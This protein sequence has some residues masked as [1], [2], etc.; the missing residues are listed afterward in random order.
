[1]LNVTRKLYSEII[2]DIAC[3][4]LFP[5][6]ETNSLAEHGKSPLVVAVVKEWFL[7]TQ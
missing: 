4:C 7:H 5:S 3:K 2:E 1:M 6:V